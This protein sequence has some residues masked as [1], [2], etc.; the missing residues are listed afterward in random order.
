MTDKNDNIVSLTAKI[1][2]RRK[3]AARKEE[4]FDQPSTELPEPSKEDV[5][6]FLRVLG[7]LRQIAPDQT[8]S[9]EFN[10]TAAH[11]SLNSNRIEYDDDVPQVNVAMQIQ[12]V[13]P[14]SWQGITP[15]DLPEIEDEDEDEEPYVLFEE[16]AEVSHDIIIQLD[17]GFNSVE[18][19]PDAE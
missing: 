8:G 5:H 19:D 16:C 14:L 11:I 15:E 18:E 2:E 4:E 12:G 1:E 17:S 9:I 3:A 13:L 7:W 6:A 10:E